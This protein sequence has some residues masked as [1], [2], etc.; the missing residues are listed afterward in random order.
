M[1]LLSFNRDVSFSS[2]GRGSA[3]KENILQVCRI[4]VVLYPGGCMCSAVDISKVSVPRLRE[5]FMTT[6]IE[7]EFFSII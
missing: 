6:V 4:L 2:E 3:A 7:Q 1:L 5:R